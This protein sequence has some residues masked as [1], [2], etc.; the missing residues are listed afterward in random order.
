MC[1]RV[2]NVLPLSR[3]PTSNLDIR[4]RFYQCKCCTLSPEIKIQ[5]SKKSSNDKPDATASIG[6]SFICLIKCETVRSGS[7]NDKC[8][9]LDDRLLHSGN[10]IVT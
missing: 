10:L 2:S 3:L 8:S 6:S 1:R 4:R 7:K 9:N 5:F